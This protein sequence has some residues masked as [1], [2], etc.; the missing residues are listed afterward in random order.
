MAG[1][2]LGRAG[3]QSARMMGCNA[4]ITRGSARAIGLAVCLLGIGLG[5]CRPSHECEA[6]RLELVQTWETLRNT[7]TSRKQIPEVSNL[8]QAQEAERIRTWTA[9]EDQSELMRS[10]FETP[11]VTWPSAEKARAAIA[12]AFKPIEGSDDPMARGFAT[13]LGEADKQLDLFRQKC[14]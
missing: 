4:R 11:Q 3:L 14:R 6:S 7:A 13:T 12:Q 2:D 5:G 8:S 10:S 1:Q 9:I